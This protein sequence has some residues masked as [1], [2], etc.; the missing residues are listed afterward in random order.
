MDKLA[1]DIPRIGVLPSGPLDSICDVG[2]ITVGHC[3]LDDGPLQT[4]VTVVRPHGGDPYLDKVPAAATVLNG[5]GKSTGLVQVQELGVLETPIA[6]TN[7]FG[8]GTVANAR[9]APRSRPIPASAGAWP[10]S[11]RWCSSAT[12]AT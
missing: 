5:F 7:T 9:S 10:P 1:L 8:V 11:I 3:T 6:L 2:E 12:T 4:G